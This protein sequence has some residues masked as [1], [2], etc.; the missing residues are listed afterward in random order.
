[1]VG[2]HPVADIVDVVALS[3]PA[4]RVLGHLVDHWAQQVGLV[5]VVDALQQTG[6]ALD[7]HSGVNVLPRQRSED[8]EIL[9]GGAL[10]AFVLHEDEIPDLDEAVLVGLGAALHAVFG[11]AVVV[12]LRARAARAGDSHR[13]VVVGHPAALDALRRQ[14][15]DL[16]PQLLGLVVVVE[17]GRPQP[18]GVEPVAA[19]GDRFGQQAP[20]QFDGPALEV[21]AEGEVSGH[22]EEGVVPGGDA[23]LVDV[24]GADALLNAGGGVV[25]G[26]PL[27]QEERHELDHAGVDEQKIRIVEDHRRAG[28]LGVSGVDEVIQETLPDLMGLHGRWSL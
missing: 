7:A 27:A 26:G 19:L 20:G 8:L 23:H 17:D 1:M 16:L 21:V 24:R 12:D 6:D 13:P 22:L 28:H 4:G 10:A 15:G 11:S 2:D 14:S 5:D 9:L 3:V 25:R 18:L